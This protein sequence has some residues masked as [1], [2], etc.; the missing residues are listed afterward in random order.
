MTSDAAP[1]ATLLVVDS[2][3]QGDRVDTFLQHA[4][5]LSRLR[6]KALFEQDAVRKNGRRCKKGD[7]L[8]EGDVLEV[9]LKAEA[10]PAALADADLPLSILHEDDRL[11]FV[12]KPTGQPTHPLL[13]GEV[14]TLANALMAR[15]PSMHGVGDD[16][17]EAG[18]CHRLDTETSGVLVAAKTRE[19]W[20]FMRQQFKAG[21]AVDKR[22]LALV[23]GP[24]A[25]Q[26]EIDLP[27]L[28]M[29]DY[30]RPS[31]DEKA[32]PASS[33]FAVLSRSGSL[34]LV[35]VQIVTGVLH[36]VRAHLSAIGAPIVGDTRYGG[37]PSSRLFLHAQSLTVTHPETLK[38]MTVQSPTPDSFR[39]QSV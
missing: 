23:R 21:D 37:E 10:T 14:G 30:M 25:D 7:F 31:F 18:V 27:L 26:G 19:A 29:S 12:D 34:S 16:L 35:E 13:D 11:V 4:L 38:R 32:R 33:R 17:R 36:Q 5:T 9:K 1:S 2:Q 20:L 28:H 39:L 24:L 3:H 22:Y 6:T 15:F 8:T